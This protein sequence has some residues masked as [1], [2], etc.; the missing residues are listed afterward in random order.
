MRRVVLLSVLFVLAISAVA[1]ARSYTVG[2]FETG[3]QSGLTAPALRIGITPRHFNVERMV[4]P[5]T[6][7]ATG[8]VT[9]NDFSGF[10]Q[11]ARSAL[12]GRVSRQ[13]AFSG[14]VTQNS[15]GIVGFVKISGRVTGTT[16]TA[17]GTL[18]IQYTPTPPYNGFVPNVTYTCQGSSAY[19][20]VP[21]VALGGG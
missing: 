1:V 18:S 3:P 6:C 2:L 15:N 10:Q 5:E 21:N 7:T 14:T 8:Q 19:Q 13:G 4:I 20:S 16:L 12:A 11:N 17:T 9:I